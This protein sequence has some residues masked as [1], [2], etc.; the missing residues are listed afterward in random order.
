MDKTTILKPHLSEQAY[1]MSQGKVYVFQVPGGA[2]KHTVARAI[3]A[4][5]DVEVI[6][7]NITNIAGKAKRTIRKGGRQVKGRTTD[8]RKAYVTLKAGQSLP[9]FAAIEEEEAKEQATQEK[10][11]KAATKVAEKEAKPARR[12]GLHLG[13]KEGDK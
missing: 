1:A 10:I 7:V 9:I 3:T 8:T 13:K 6:K 5:F 12:R 11:E 4:Q 2:N